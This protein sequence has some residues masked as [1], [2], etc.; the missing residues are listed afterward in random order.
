MI[1]EQQQGN[2]RPELF[3]IINEIELTK[4]IV[5]T[6]KKY[7]NQYS[8]FTDYLR[9]VFDDK[10]KFLLPDGKP[11]YTPSNPSSVPSTWHKKHM[12]L[13]YFVE[14]GGGANDMSQ[15]K[16]ESMFIQ[17]LESIHPEDA[18]IV[19]KMV[20]KKTTSKKLT[21]TAVMEALPDLIQES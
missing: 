13:R 15:V 5:S 7:G 8:S 4:D 3:E 14:I 2:Q 16:R 19:C 9:C 12:D 11:P 6:L 21:K 1:S 17:L 10:V 20:E 18:V